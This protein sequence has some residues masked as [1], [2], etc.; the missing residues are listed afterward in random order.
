LRHPDLDERTR[1]FW[2]EYTKAT[3]YHNAYEPIMGRL[4]SFFRPPLS[5]TLSTPSFSIHQLVNGEA[6]GVLLY[7]VSKLRGLAQETMVRLVIALV[8]QAY[9][10]RDYLPQDH[11]HPAG[12]HIDEF[13]KHAPGSQQALEEFLQGMRKYRAY[14]SAAFQTTANLPLELTRTM[15]G[16]VTTLRA[17]R[18]SAQD[19]RRWAE[20][21]R[22]YEETVAGGKGCTQE[23]QDAIAQERQRLAALG[24]PSSKILESLLADFRHAQKAAMFAEGVTPMNK[25]SLRP[26]LLE[27][28]P[29]GYC[30][31]RGI[32]EI[33]GPA[34]LEV[35]E[36]P[37]WLAPQT[38][39]S[40]QELIEESKR[41]YG[42]V[43]KPEIPPRKEKET[44]DDHGDERRE[45]DDD[46]DAMFVIRNA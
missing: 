6:P 35:P 23:L 44:P 16:T 19:A 38:D 20:E 2:A 4:G 43:T 45:D 34:L 46:D 11:W 41:R 26:D 39:K 14:L 9:S 42:L 17:F 36:I 21:L 30:I 13:Q 31:M 12:L 8:H 5:I 40:P 7:D 27:T 29:V 37:P 1:K 15:F 25:T 33:T 10:A 3:Y 18:L 24:A 32:P 28:L 22:L